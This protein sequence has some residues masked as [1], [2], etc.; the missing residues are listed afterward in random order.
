M[1]FTVDGPKK[2]G[3]VGALWVGRMIDYSVK[4]WLHVL[5]T[6]PGVPST[7]ISPEFGA[8]ATKLCPNIRLL[9]ATFHT[10]INNKEE[11]PPRQ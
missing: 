5:A 2:M 10:S 6:S 3:T 4:K 9:E 11:E 8:L 7:K 1:T